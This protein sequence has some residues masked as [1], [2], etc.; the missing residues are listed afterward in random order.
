MIK[1]IR[2]EN[3]H[4]KKGVIEAIFYKDLN[5]LT[6]INGSG[7]TTI[8]KILWYLQSGNITRCISEFSFD[9]LLF[10]TDISTIL[11]MKNNNNNKSINCDYIINFKHM[12]ENLSDKIVLYYINSNIKSRE[13]VEELENYIAEY[14]Q[15]SLFFP[16]FRR[17]EGV[18]NNSNRQST[19]RYRNSI[20]D[21]LSASLED[22][23][24]AFSSYKH[25]FVTSISTNDISK[26][27]D[28]KNSEI[29][30]KIDKK[31]VTLSRIIETKV[32]ATDFESMELMSYKNTLIEIYEKT[33][34]ISEE[35]DILL[36]PII[37]LTSMISEILKYKGIQLSKT[38]LGISD[39]SNDII[40]SEK[41]SAGEK[42]MLSFFCYNAFNKD[43]IIFIDE[44]EL[45]L[46]VDW[47]RLLMPKLMEQSSNNQFII[48]THSPFIYSRYPDKEIEL[49]HNK[50]DNIEE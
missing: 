34:T 9:V 48:A 44:P 35:R 14:S 20:E 12:D 28:E 49:N 38:V 19:S 21:R 30:Q 8:L 27:V 26:L 40:S 31:Y 11:I 13:K 2:I 43:S 37:V 47:Q 18:S 45:S 33:Q 36:T 50:G 29:S 4:G 3:L 1:S 24:D 41:L 32:N 46:H 22:I 23:S 39:I 5:L 15:S 17:I 6:G 16:T 10:S 7:K 25:K 42:Q